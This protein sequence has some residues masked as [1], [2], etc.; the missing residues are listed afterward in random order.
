M[1]GAVGVECRDGGSTHVDT[2]K[3]GEGEENQRLQCLNVKDGQLTIR[4]RF[5]SSKRFCS[6]IW[7]RGGV[8]EVREGERFVTAYNRRL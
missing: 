1:S 5:R 2:T 8:S 4:E 6:K 3:L 7:E